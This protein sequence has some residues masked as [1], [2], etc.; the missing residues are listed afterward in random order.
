MLDKWPEIFVNYNS[1]FC[2][3]T[4]D[5]TFCNSF[6]DRTSTNRE[7]HQAY[8]TA[9]VGYSQLWAQSWVILAYVLLDRTG[10]AFHI[11]VSVNYVESV[12]TS[13][14]R[15]PSKQMKHLSYLLT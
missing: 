14:S 5:L 12:E 8:K 6:E 9:E 11:K 4:S 1:S 3:K 10:N 7:P 2:V 15:N 13:S